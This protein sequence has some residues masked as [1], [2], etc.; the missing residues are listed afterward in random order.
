MKLSTKAFLPALLVCSFSISAY[1]Q[2][3][4]DTRV[5]L[6]WNLGTP[7]IDFSNDT[8]TD[9]FDARFILKG[10]NSIS[11]E[12]ANLGIN[13]GAP[14]ASLHISDGEFWSSHNFG[15]SLVIDGAHHNALGIFDSGNA[16]PIAL[17]NVNG[18]LVMAKMPALWNTTSPPV[19]ILELQSSGAVQI[20]ALNSGTDKRLRIPGTYN[21]EEM[22]VKMGPNGNGE[23]E[24]IT[25]SNATNSGGVKL[26]S[27]DGANLHFQ[28]ASP[29]SAAGSLAYSTK[30]LITN[31]GRVGIGTVN[32]NGYRLAVEGTVGAREVNVN[33]VTWSDY[34]FYD[35]Y[36]LPSLKSVEGYISRYKHLPEIPTTEEVQKNGINVGEMNALLLKK[37]EELTLYMIEQEKKMERMQSK[38]EQLSKK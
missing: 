4:V 8:N 17:A 26:L 6:R 38:I 30:M 18:S 5:E 9:D 19:H 34:V 28:T 1:A 2:I 3:P 16:N 27:S 14:A 32:T 22:N 11:L 10:Q 21:F 24:F 37:I 23:L 7:Y 20:G 15:A 33:A 35:D 31:D 12:G 13:N 29:Q 25:H 36:K